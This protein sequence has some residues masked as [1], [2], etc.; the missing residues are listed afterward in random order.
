MSQKRR[1][2]FLIARIHQTGGRIFARLL[3]E[4]GID[5]I[6]PAQGRILFVLWEEDGIPITRLAEKTGL[7]KSTMTAMLDRLEKQGYIKRTFPRDDRRSILIYRT[8]KDKKLQDV[9][10]KVS[11]R[12]T[13]FFYSGFSGDEITCFEALLERIDR[14]LTRLEN[15][16]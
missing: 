11:D 14:N 1:G 4:Q 10:A 9:Y 16:L 3:K 12:M 15:G 7:G 8:E 6:N 5:E 13:S 2:G